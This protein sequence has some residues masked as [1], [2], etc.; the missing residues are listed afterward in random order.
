MAVYWKLSLSGTLGELVAGLRNSSRIL[1]KKII[2]YTSAK[3]H[4]K[5]LNVIPE[6]QRSVFLHAPVR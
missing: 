2:G 4:L 3:S 5:L 1:K 6:I